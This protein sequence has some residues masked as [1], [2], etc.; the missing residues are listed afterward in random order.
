MSEAPP[1]AVLFD[2][3]LTLVTFRFPRSELVT[4]MEDVRPW[5]GPDAPPAETLVDDVLLPIDR[6]LAEF[7]GCLDEVD[8]LDFFD[9]GW[10]RAGFEVPRDTLYRILDVEQRCWDGAAT[11]APDAL[12]T[13]DGLRARGV[14][15]GVCSNAPFPP[16]MVRRQ[17]CGK[18][19]TQ[20]TDAVVLSSEVGRRKP[21]PEL[22]EAALEALGAEA[23]E[24]LHVG[25][26]V[27]EDFEGPRAVGMRAVLCTALARHE[28]P[29]DVPT[30]VHLEE[31][32]Q[33]IR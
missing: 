19:I 17:L 18:G 1:R 4:A 29:P 13:L 25:D 12:A 8:Y 27:R 24:T 11:P 6:G 5:L 9:R 22:Y 21:A 23:G 28:P 31:L 15:T 30:I 32:L 26:K 10:R 16:E 2:Y 3:G 20:R 7:D 14:R 33:W